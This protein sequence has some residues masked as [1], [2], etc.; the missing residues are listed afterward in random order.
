MVSLIIRQM[1]M[2]IAR[3]NKLEYITETYHEYKKEKEEFI[4]YLDKKIRRETKDR[5]GN[6]E[7]DNGQQKVSKSGGGDTTSTGGGKKKSNNKKKKE[8]DNE[9]L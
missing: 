5:D 7:R 6:S 3:V 9:N 1:E 8:N 4:K 2:T